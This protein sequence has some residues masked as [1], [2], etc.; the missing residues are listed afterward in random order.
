V[1]P[2]QSLSE[3]GSDL[4]SLDSEEEALDYEAQ[5]EEQ[6]E[7][8]YQ[9]YLHRKGEQTIGSEVCFR[10]QACCD[11][12]KQVCGVCVV[13]LETRLACVCGVRLGLRLVLLW[14]W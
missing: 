10:D 4:S 8:A 14:M 5:L 1:A 7:D 9:Q 11:A 3:G 12:Y 2:L 13:F 6:L